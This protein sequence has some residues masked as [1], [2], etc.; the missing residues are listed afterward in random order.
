M[1]AAE[2]R[3]GMTEVAVESGSGRGEGREESSRWRWWR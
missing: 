1:V 3:E 2:E